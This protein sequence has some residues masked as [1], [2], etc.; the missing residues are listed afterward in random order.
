MAS[1][2]HG[3]GVHRSGLKLRR[4]HP[5]RSHLDEPSRVDAAGVRGPTAGEARGPNWRRVA[6]GW[7]VHAAVDG[8][9]PEQRI[10]EAAYR[11]PPGGA[12]TGWAALH[13]LGCGWLDGTAYD[14]GLRPVSVVTGGRSWRPSPG[15]RVSQEF[16]RPG[17]LLLVDG[18]PVAV[19]QSAVLFEA[20]H[21]DALRAAVV[22]I[23]MAAATDLTSL[24]ELATVV[25]LEPPRTGI[26]QA[27]E[28]LGLAVEN[29]WSP[30]ESRLRLVWQLDAEL[31]PVLCNHP[32]FDLSGRL[33]GI[34]DLLDEEAGL[35][36]EYEGSAHLDVQRRR[37][38]VGRDRSFRAVGLD[39]LTVMNGDL[40]RRAETAGLLRAARRHARRGTGLRLWTTTLPPWWIPADTVARRR[41]L[42]P[43]QRSRALLPP[44]RPPSR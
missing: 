3:A 30:T 44:G 10:L 12:I 38:D 4:P 41:A 28:A 42:T 1:A 17:D 32:V 14:G 24:D 39:P 20:R 36:V 40:P 35:V 8:T 43:H 21:A 19:P 7:V 27:R 18:V 25:A 23:D 13:W 34:P 37:S 9:N 26:A 29:S 5:I 22:A 2:S 16:I 31:G 6:P 33:V 11:V 15:V